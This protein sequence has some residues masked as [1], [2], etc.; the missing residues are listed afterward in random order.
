MSIIVS[1]Y[2]KEGIVMSADSR[3]T[4]ITP[5]KDGVRDQYTV[6]D[7]GQKLFLIK[8][9]NIGISSCGDQTLDGKTIADF[10]RCFELEEVRSE[11]TVSDVANKLAAYVKGKHAGIVIFHV[12]GYVNTLHERGHT[13]AALAGSRRGRPWVSD[14]AWDVLVSSK[15]PPKKQGTGKQQMRCLSIPL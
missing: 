15:N 11:D 10:I 12:C 4:G 2:L 8:N 7:N 14:H 9:G 1:V 5:C 3:L 13:P 6:S